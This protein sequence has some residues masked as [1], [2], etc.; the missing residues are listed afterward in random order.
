MGWGGIRAV[1]PARRVCVCVCDSCSV[2]M[3]SV[4]S[5]VA[6]C[7]TY[8]LCARVCKACGQHSLGGRWCGSWGG[9]GWDSWVRWGG[10]HATESSMQGQCRWREK[11]CLVTRP[12]GMQ[13]E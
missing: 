5:R 10:A 2:C 7:D 13:D 4:R 3:L 1:E 6:W 12:S 9:Q 11:G 8:T